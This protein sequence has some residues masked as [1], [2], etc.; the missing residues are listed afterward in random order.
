MAARINML[1]PVW[2]AKLP[3]EI[4]VL[5]LKDMGKMI[6]LG[7]AT[8]ILASL[9]GA[10]TELNPTST[11]FGK[12]HVGNTRW[13]IWG[14]FQ[15][16]IR[17]FSQIASGYEKK[18]DGS[19]VP[20]GTERGQH[21]RV[22]KLLNLFRGKLAPVPSIA[23]DVLAGKTAVGEDVELTPELKEHLIP[24]IYGDV[25]EAWKEQGPMSILYT[26]VP[27]FLGVGTT[28]YEQKASGGSHSGKP[29]KPGKPSKPTKNT[30]K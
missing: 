12:I 8:L 4:R 1:N 18:G 16:Y 9:G 24:M 23:T 19:I 14:G 29:D 5:A 15:Q 7:S 10:K 13:D 3:K 6:G 26:G 27:S 11:D 21:T 20:L 28:T 25:K 17:A 22:E 2:Y 30:K